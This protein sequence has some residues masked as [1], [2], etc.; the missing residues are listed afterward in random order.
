ML[1][2]DALRECSPDDRDFAVTELMI[3]WNAS[4]MALWYLQPLRGLLERVAEGE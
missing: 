2:R 1:A 4:H 3:C